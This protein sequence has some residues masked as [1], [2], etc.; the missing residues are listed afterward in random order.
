MSSEG[1]AP[2]GGGRRP[3]AHNDRP[4]NRQPNRS[5]N[6]TIA[7]IERALA[8]RV[9][10][11]I[12]HVDTMLVQVDPDDIADPHARAVLVAVADH[13][14][15]AEYGLCSTVLAL[16]ARSLGACADAADGLAD[17]ATT[18]LLAIVAKATELRKDLADIHRLQAGGKLPDGAA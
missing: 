14:A 16:P 6:D 15:T 9:A 17:I 5:T 7:N 13:A 3:E 1:N 8:H 10:V 4:D 2:G 11:G 18:A 12:V